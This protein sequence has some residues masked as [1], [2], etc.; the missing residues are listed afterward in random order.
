MARKK[1]IIM[2]LDNQ[3]VKDISTIQFN[4]Y[5]TDYTNIDSLCNKYENNYQEFIAF[6]RAKSFSTKVY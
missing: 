5:K 3:I 2:N 6:F 1:E 4:I